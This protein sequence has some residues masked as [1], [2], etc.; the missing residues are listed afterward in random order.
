MI[1][2]SGISDLSS[3]EMFKWIKK[4][5]CILKKVLYNILVWAEYGRYP[6][7]LQLECS[8]HY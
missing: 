6:W 2:I 3:K 5:L 7:E 4:N 1:I 8:G